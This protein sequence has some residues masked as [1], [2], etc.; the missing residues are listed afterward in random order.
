M[1]TADSLARMKGRVERGEQPWAA[2]AEN[3]LRDAAGD[4]HLAPRPET[5]RDSFRFYQAAVRDGERAR[6]LA[7]ASLLSGDDRFAKASLAHLTAWATAQPAPASDFD[8]AIRF[9]NS[10]MEVARAAIPFLEA[11]D[12]LADHPSLAE[13][14]RTA[15]ESWFR[16][17]VQPILS[18]K[19]RWRENGYFNGQNFQ[20]HLTAHTMGLAALGYALGDR[21][22]VQF[23]L[24]HP[25]NDRDFRTLI[26]G[27]I[28][29]EGQEAH[30]REPPSAP[31][32]ADG[33]I[34]DRYRH[35]T[36]KRGRGIQYVHLSLSQLIYTAEIAWNNGID[37]YDYTA[38]GGENLKLPLIFYA[39]LFRTGDLSSAGGTFASGDDALRRQEKLTLKVRRDFPSIYEV[40]NR[41]YPREPAIVSVLK[42]LDRSSVPRHP[43]TSFFFPVLTHA[44]PIEP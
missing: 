9:P 29:M 40:G 26:E 14:D 44:E 22:L 23:A 18:G 2:A 8:P 30:H 12:L 21:E 39:E 38:P 28:L 17:L 16:L 24:D 15:I 10:G 20:N 1:F 7:Y 35:F 27:M 31:P 42:S 4:R 11:Y 43:H 34:M 36:G 19:E 41:R 13:A 33:E 37:F 25:E 5:G 6:L 3:L 32:P